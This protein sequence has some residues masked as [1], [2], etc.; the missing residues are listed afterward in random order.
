MSEHVG[1]SLAFIFGG[2]IFI[3]SGLAGIRS[4]DISAPHGGRWGPW[5]RDRNPFDFWNAVCFRFILSACMFY[6]AWR[7]YFGPP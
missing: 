1:W 6:A 2:L 5:Y 4:G 3:A 7:T